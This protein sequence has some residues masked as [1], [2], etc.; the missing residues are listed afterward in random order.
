MNQAQENLEKRVHQFKSDPIRLDFLRLLM[1]IINHS[2]S[3]GV[4]T[5]ENGQA[6]I[7]FETEPDDERYYKI[8]KMLTDY[9][10]TKYPDLIFP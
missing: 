2:P 9:E 5:F 6:Q 3:K 4:L 8:S 7:K 1:E 10:E